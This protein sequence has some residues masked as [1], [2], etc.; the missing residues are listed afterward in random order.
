MSALNFQSRKKWL[1]IENRYKTYQKNVELFLAR[2]ELKLE[3]RF[4][5]NAVPA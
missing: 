1:K 3:L 4:F 2:I 5:E